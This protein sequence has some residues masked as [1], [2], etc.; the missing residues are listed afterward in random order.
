M[1]GK[2]PSAASAEAAYADILSR[3]REA[4]ALYEGV[5]GTDGRFREYILVDANQ[6]YIALLDLSRDVRPGLS[7]KDDPPR[8]DPCLFDIF[9]RLALEKKEEESFEARSLSA[10]SPRGPELYRGLAFR[11][12]ACFFAC[13]LLPLHAD[14]I[15]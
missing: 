13:L 5:G 2:R 4:F 8:L 14:S 15:D 10:P 7:L 3:L 9:D 12:G 11:T 1:S 6:A